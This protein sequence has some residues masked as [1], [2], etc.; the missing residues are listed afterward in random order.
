MS[1]KVKNDVIVLFGATGDLA[2]KK[3]FPAI[4][5]LY[6]NDWFSGAIVGVSFADWTTEQLQTFAHEAVENALGKDE[7]TLDSKLLEKML[8]NI[9][10]VSGDYEDNATFVKLAETINSFKSPLYYLAIPPKMFEIVL[11]SLGVNKLNPPTSRVVVEKPFGRN[12]ETAKKLNDVIHEFFA[13]ENVMRIDHFLGKQTIE[14]LLVVRFANSLLEPLWNR[15][16]IESVQITMAEKFSAGESGRGAFYD[17]VG[18]IADVVQNHLLEIVTLLAMEPPNS[19][20]HED[21]LAE[22]VKVLT[23]IAPVNPHEV[24]RGQYRKFRDETGVNPASN[25]ET[26]AA[27]KLHINN[28]RWTGVPF[29]LRTGKS[30]PLTATEAVVTFKQPPRA[31]F[32]GME[33]RPNTLKFRLGPNSQISLHLSRKEDHSLDAVP[34]DLSVVES[35]ATRGMPDAYARLL[36]DALNGEKARF[37]HLESVLNAWRIVEPALGMQELSFYEA[38]TWGPTKRADALTENYSPWYDPQ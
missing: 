11:S 21:I 31:L 25:T 12:V 30:L 2:R 3:L 37:A 10:M 32:P 15:N 6:R 38:N 18:A 22:K 1:T 14:E 7:P 23:A 29:L 36:K 33:K 20:N 9:V 16:H 5:R 34:V 4:Y 24:V 19:L 17:S 26:Y 27:L 28:W 8:T 35:E 13:E